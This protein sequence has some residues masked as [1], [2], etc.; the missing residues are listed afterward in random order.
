MTAS[1]VERLSSID[2]KL[3]RGVSWFGRVVYPGFKIRSIQSSKFVASWDSSAY[4]LV[5]P[6]LSFNPILVVSTNRDE[7]TVLTRLVTF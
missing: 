3:K 5:M 6:A 1:G 2:L 4:R 7:V